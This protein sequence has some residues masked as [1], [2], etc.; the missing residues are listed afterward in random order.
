ML[1]LTQYKRKTYDVKLPDGQRLKLKKPTQ[2]FALTLVTLT[3]ADTADL[4]EIFDNVIDVVVKALN[5]NEEGLKF[6]AAYVEE[7]FNFE[8][9][10]ALINGYAEFM[11]ELIN[12]KN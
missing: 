6:D 9:C 3:E 4:A 8:M 7:N 10:M 2:R 11:T 1:D 12:Q 5:H